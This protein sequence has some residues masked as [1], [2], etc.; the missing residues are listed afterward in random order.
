V[1]IVVKH[2]RRQMHVLNSAACALR[3]MS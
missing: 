3:V 2:L 1:R